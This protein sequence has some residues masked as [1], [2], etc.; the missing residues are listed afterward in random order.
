MP[1]EPFD[2]SRDVDVMDNACY[3][4][5]HE[6]TSLFCSNF[7]LPLF[8]LIWFQTELK[9]VD[10]SPDWFTFGT[11]EFVEACVYTSIR[12]EVSGDVI[13]SSIQSPVTAQH[14]TTAVCLPTPCQSKWDPVL[15]ALRIVSCG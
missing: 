12:C 7:I 1:K 13:N 2:L 9:D 4:L 15:F 14:T 8:M 5:M 10:D 11:S 6:W 3:L